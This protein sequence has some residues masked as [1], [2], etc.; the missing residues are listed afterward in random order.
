M[1]QNSVKELRSGFELIKTAH[2]EPDTGGERRGL[3]GEVCEKF[4]EISATPLL[5]E[6]GYFI[7]R[8]TKIRWYESLSNKK[9]GT[10]EL[11]IAIYDSS[12]NLL[13][14]IEVKDYGDSTQFA[15]SLTSD[16]LVRGIHPQCKFV[17]ISI[18][19]GSSQDLRDAMINKIGLKGITHALN[20]LPIKRDSKK[21]TYLD[22]FSDDQLSDHIKNCVEELSKI[23]K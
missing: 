1:I 4:I 5:K 21:S 8:H 22:Q 13:W 7:K 14:G 11:D 6:L 15:A 17:F 16:L 9:E 10:K 18:H 19:A 2:N 12:D 3:K 20:V 23:I